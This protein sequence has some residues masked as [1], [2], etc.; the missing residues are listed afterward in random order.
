MQFNTIEE[1]RVRVGGLIIIHGHLERQ[2]VFPNLF[3][4]SPHITVIHCGLWG[5]SDSHRMTGFA[6]A[7][8][9]V[10]EIYA[11]DPGKKSLSDLNPRL[12]ID[13]RVTPANKIRNSFIQQ[14]SF[15]GDSQENVHETCLRDAQSL[16]ERRNK[17]LTLTGTGFWCGSVQ[18]T[19]IYG[20]EGYLE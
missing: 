18:D 20:I 12:L 17:L 15:Q 6:E 16:F 8:R 10:K 9:D 2:P 1:F 11:N 4:R 7:F 13:Q 19:C 5:E 3:T 14:I